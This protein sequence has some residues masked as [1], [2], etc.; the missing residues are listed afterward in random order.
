MPLVVISVNLT[1]KGSMGERSRTF[2]LSQKQKQTKPN[3][4][5]DLIGRMSQCKNKMGAQEMAQGFQATATV[6]EDQLWFPAP[7][8]AHNHL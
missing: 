8:W 2:S 7:N 3:R 1:V 4:A 5:G 6:V